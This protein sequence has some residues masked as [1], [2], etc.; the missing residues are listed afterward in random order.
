[1]PAAWLEQILSEEQ[2]LLP[3]H[4]ACA[5]C[6]P[7]ISMRHVLGAL[8]AARPES[9]IVLVVPA[10]CWTIIA[11]VF[12]VDAFGVCV[13]LTPF[14]SA[15]AEASG[16]KSA[17]RLRGDRDT[18]VVVWGG[19]GSTSDIGFSGVS[20]AAERNEDIVYVLNDNEAYMNTGVQKSGATP[21]GAWT[22]TTPASSPKTGQKKDI[23]RIM[24][25]HRIPY[26]ATLA[27]GSVPMLR[28]FRAKV[29]RAAEIDGFR[30]LHILSG[31]PPGWRYPTAQSTEVTRLAV[32]SRYFPL[33]ECDHGEW[34]ITFQP[35]HPVPVGAFLGTQGRFSHLSSDAIDSI[36]AHIDERWKLIAGLPSG[37]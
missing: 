14:A 19:D 30:F 17:L 2:L 27:L 12:P 26:V 1:V 22:T 15:A 28:D 8:A 34:R 5:G 18:I 11:G 25:A 21:E 32:E 20:A 31:C 4:S 9:K 29:T 23:A 3:G 24:A 10:S 6:G 16:I 13:H 37:A 33:F 36:Q 7:A 35:K